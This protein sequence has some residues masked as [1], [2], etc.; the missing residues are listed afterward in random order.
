[1]QVNL[2]RHKDKP[3]TEKAYLFAR[4]FPKPEVWI[5]V[6]VISHVSQKTIPDKDGFCQVVVTV[7]DWFAREHNL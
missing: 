5:P 3:G 4:R 2:L 7:E 6:S 1:M